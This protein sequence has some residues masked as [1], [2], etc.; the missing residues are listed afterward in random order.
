MSLPLYQVDAFSP[1]PF[2]GNPAAVCL[3]DH[4]RPDAWMTALAAEMNLSETAFVLPEG[5]GYRLRWMTPKVEVRLCGHATL[6]SAHI[7]FETSK[8]AP[9][10]TL[11]FHTLSG[12]LTARQVDGWI[13]LN[14]PVKSVAASEP[15]A[16]LMEALGVQ[17]VWVGRNEQTYLV[18]VED[19]ETVRSA[20]PN[21]AALAS[22]PLRYV[23][24]TSRGRSGGA[25]D[26]VSRY[27][28]P[29]AGIAEDPVTGSAHCYVIDY[30]GQ[31]LGKDQLLA[32]Q[33]SARGGELRL[34]RQGERV[35]I[36]G[37]A[38]TILRGEL[39]AA[40]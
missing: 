27:F 2:R 25:Y 30:W 28:A 22:L 19:E 4:P 10:D 36:R 6:A 3:L 32:Y 14:F 31:K 15:P 7:L 26:C 20:Q 24:L 11:H 5:T 21:H 16:G 12:E 35:L 29:G 38:V 18:E 17:P 39:L 9:N 13:E 40:D 34:V 1:V 8:A 33:A 23:L 37:Q